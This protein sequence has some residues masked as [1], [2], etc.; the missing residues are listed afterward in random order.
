GDNGLPRWLAGSGVAID[1]LRGRWRLQVD[2]DSP[3]D[4]FL[5]DPDRTRDLLADRGVAVDRLRSKLAAV[6]AL[7]AD[8]G[9]E[10]P[11]AGRAAAGGLGWL[12]RSTA[13]RTRAL[14]EERGF[15]TR[16]AAGSGPE[17]RPVRSSLGL[18]LDRDGPEAFGT[19][20]AELGDAALVDTRVVL[21][22]RF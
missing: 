15:R 17:Q 4:T 9:R 20:L 13:S 8:P 7:A 16:E 22:H 6:A 18:L 3:L 12:E 5:V 10:P 1:D 14:I 11:L 21:A 19:R 2:L